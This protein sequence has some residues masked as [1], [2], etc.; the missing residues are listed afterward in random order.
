MNSIFLCTWYMWKYI[1]KNKN[2]I[3]GILI[4][5]ILVNWGK[6]I[7]IEGMSEKEKKKM[8]KMAKTQI[9][10]LDSGLKGLAPY[11]DYGKMA[12]EN[13][14]ISKDEKGKLLKYLNYLES[15]LKYIALV[16]LVRK[17]KK[18][19]GNKNAKKQFFSFV[20]VLGTLGKNKQTKE[21]MQKQK[22]IDFYRKIISGIIPYDEK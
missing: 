4:I 15:L 22:E 3:M 13:M 9:K 17:T 8:E 16:E 11:K 14:R 21:Q 19:S 10:V 20:G 5:I 12:G 7:T 6:G 18:S 2:L 1:K